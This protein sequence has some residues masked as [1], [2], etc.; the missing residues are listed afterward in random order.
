MY[1]K[2]IGKRKRE[3]GREKEVERD[4]LFLRSAIGMRQTLPFARANYSIANRTVEYGMMMKYKMTE[5][6][7]G[8]RATL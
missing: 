3:R 7:G 8:V 5:Y 1:E 4:W 6:R 2:N